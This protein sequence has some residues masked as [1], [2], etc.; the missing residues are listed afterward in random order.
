MKA[1]RVGGL[2]GDLPLAQAARRIVAIRTA[3]LY[4]FVPE[5]L[6]EDAVT[7]MHDMRI[8]AKRLRY[9]LEMVGVC[10]GEVGEEA[11]GRAKA[12]QEV[13]GDIHDCDV[14]LARIEHSRAAAPDG[15]DAL[16]TRFREDRARAFA[17]FE[18][19]WSQIEAGGLRDRLLA[20]TFSS[21]P[22]E[23]VSA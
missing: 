4:A 7:A 20:T 2:D 11:R 14:M 6:D 3:E 23:T 12:L 8:A 1:H 21:P 15:F 19:L 16:A 22:Q 13:L 5:A 17:R 10:F 18:A 9:L